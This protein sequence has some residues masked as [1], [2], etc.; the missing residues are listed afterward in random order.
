VRAGRAALLGLADL[1]ASPRCG[2]CGRDEGSPLCPECLVRCRRPSGPTCRRCGNTWPE[3]RHADE[4]CGRCRRFGRPFAFETAAALWRYAGPARELVHAFKYRGRGDCLAPLG[5]RLADEPRLKWLWAGRPPERSLAERW[6]PEGRLAERW[7]PEGRLAERW[8]PEGRLAERWL[9]V[10]LPARAASRR[11]RGYDQARLLAEALAA[12]AGLACAPA[13]L[14]R[15]RASG[16]QAG[17]TVGR[18]KAAV[19][20][21]LRARPWLVAGRPVL[22]VDDVLSTGASADAAARALRLA[23]ARTVRVAVLAT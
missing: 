21:V 15:R 17:A 9:V 20:G 1:L 2:A 5:R 16:P 13:A 8:L 22:L 11:R 18:R 19:R 14:V 10:P 3:G 7:L 12:R 4:G 23:G 6:L